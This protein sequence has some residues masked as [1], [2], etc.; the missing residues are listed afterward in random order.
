MDTKT[1]DEPHSDSKANSRSNWL[2]AAVLGSNDGIVSIA[3]LVVGVAGATNSKLIILAAG[4][5]GIL[6]GALSMAAGEYVSVSTQRDI[7]KTLLHKEREELRSQPKEELEE[8]VSLYEAKGLKPSTARIVANELTAKDAFAAHVDI[9]L[10]IDP[11]NLTNAW[12]AAY[13]S[14]ISFFIGSII[15]LGV[16]M[17]P[18]GSVTIPVT[19]V[20]V[21]VA[22]V[23]TGYLSAKLAGTNLPKSIL[24]VVIGGAAAMLITYTIGTLFGVSHL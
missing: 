24:R 1:H 20:S 18:L 16:V 4:V 9:E 10:N 13:A 14:S 2:R 19:F 12:H 5:A 3:G 23:I 22:L 8:L 15:P 11:N 7:E 6:A 21:I 17:L